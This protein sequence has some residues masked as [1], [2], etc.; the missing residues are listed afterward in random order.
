MALTILVDTCMT[1]CSAMRSMAHFVLTSLVRP[2][3]AN[4]TLRGSDSSHCC[5]VWITCSSRSLEVGRSFLLYLVLPGPR[6]GRRGGERP[7]GAAAGGGEP[8]Q[9][10]AAHTR[11][12]L[13]YGNCIDQ[14]CPSFLHFIAEN[15]DQSLSSGQLASTSCYEDRT[16]GNPAQLERKSERTGLR[17]N[18]QQQL[19]NLQREIS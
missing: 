10:G 6:P 12:H 11:G 8:H 18:N 13:Q 14:K 4:L 9:R 3:T 1:G 5:P 2:V 7:A 17:F 19:F 16:R 15:P